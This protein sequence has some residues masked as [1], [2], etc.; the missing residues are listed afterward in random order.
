MLAALVLYFASA[1]LS[2][3]GQ[4]AVPPTSHAV[5]A[6]ASHRQLQSGTGPVCNI[7]STVCNPVLGCTCVDADSGIGGTSTCTYST[8]A[9][10]N[11][12][13]WESRYSPLFPR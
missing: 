8:L 9:W 10:P 2:A 6:T 12:S 5:A 3:A 1:Q 4:V 13:T 7:L 11:N